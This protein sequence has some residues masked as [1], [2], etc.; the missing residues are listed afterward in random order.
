[1]RAN[2]QVG[3][4]SAAE[5]RTEVHSRKNLITF[6][7]LPSPDTPPQKKKMSPVYRTVSCIVTLVCNNSDAAS[8]N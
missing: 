2:K 4:C 1:M 3:E 5:M 6:Q 8:V 7:Q